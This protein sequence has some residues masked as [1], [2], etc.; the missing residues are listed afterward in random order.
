[1]MYSPHV[2][3]NN[4]FIM[5]TKNRVEDIGFPNLVFWELTHNFSLEK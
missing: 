5:I 3:S 2:L 4:P 1:M